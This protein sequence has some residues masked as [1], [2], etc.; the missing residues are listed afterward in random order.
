MKLH[1]GGAAQLLLEL[2]RVWADELSKH[3][4]RMVLLQEP[5]ASLGLWRVCGVGVFAALVPFRVFRSSGGDS[6]G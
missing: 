1:V 4:V 6:G 2:L 3:L 5:K